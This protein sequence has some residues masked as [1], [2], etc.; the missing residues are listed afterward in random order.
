VR[1]RDVTFVD[2]SP[3]GR[4]DLFAQTR[5]HGVPVAASFDGT[6]VHFETPQPRVA[7]GQVVALYTGDALVGGGIAA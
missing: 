3:V 4:T 5:A 2:A 7:P 6:T 1:L